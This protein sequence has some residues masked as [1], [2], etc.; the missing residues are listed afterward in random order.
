MART[1]SPVKE[2]KRGRPRKV[3]PGAAPEEKILNHIEPA[4]IPVPEPPPPPE[5]E[6]DLGKELE[7][8]DNPEDANTF[9]PTANNRLLDS[10]MF[11]TAR[12]PI[13]RHPLVAV[14]GHNNPHFACMCF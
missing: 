10:Q 13:C 7:D 3:M 9:K 4:W 8:E 6:L 12:C 2:K 5:A 11:D 14:C 1:A